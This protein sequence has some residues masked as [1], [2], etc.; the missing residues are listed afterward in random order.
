MAATDGALALSGSEVAEE[1]SL[2][3]RLP[4]DCRAVFDSS[5]EV[6]LASDALIARL[7]EREEAPWGDLFGKPITA[8]KL[9]SLLRPY[10]VRPSHWRGGAGTS[11][12]YRRSAFEDAW[13]R[14]LGSEAA[15]AAQPA[16]AAVLT[17]RKAAQARM[18]C[19]FKNSRFAGKCRLCR[20]KWGYEGPGQVGCSPVD[21]K[22]GEARTG[23]AD[24]Q[25]LKLEEGRADM[26]FAVAV[27]VAAEV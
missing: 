1:D 18:V 20:F 16:I 8:R 22:R 23:L 15:H 10:D 26:Q 25:L 24:L 2:G 27:L 6:S 9:A 14:Y 21:P 17:I 5:G 19:R 11:R 4:A 12:G 7:V 3:V 13:S